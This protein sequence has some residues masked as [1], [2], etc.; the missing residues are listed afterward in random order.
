MCS[1]SDSRR[2]TPSRSLGFV[3]ERF[4]DRARRVVVL[5]QEEA[6][7]FNHT[8]IGTE[9]LLLGI[10]HE[11]QGVAAQTLEALEIRL[12]V[13]RGAVER[14]MQRGASPAVGAPQFTPRAKQ[15]LEDALRESLQLGHNY[16]GTEHMLLGLLHNDDSVA[17]RVLR[18]L[19]A[20]Y[21]RARDEV[22]AVLADRPVPPEESG[23]HR[24]PDQ[25]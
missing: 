19:G 15:A 5:A 8:A 10:V 7:L 20:T 21:E 24:L 18:D 4:T 23:V 6:R 1:A 14:E 16:I 9:H 17:S 12:P 2:S 22:V 13:V 25:P 11:G 3:F